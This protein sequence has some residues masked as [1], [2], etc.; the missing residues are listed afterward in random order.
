MAAAIM[1]GYQLLVLDMRN[2]AQCRE[3]FQSN[4]L[5]GAVI[6]AGLTVSILFA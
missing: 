5:V 3:L 6:F 1:F 2:P 4:H